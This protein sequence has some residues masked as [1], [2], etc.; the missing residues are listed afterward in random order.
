[1]QCF[2]QDFVRLVAAGDINLI[3]INLHMYDVIASSLRT[4][5]LWH[6]RSVILYEI[7]CTVIQLNTQ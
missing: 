3:Y 7:S 2:P 6:F 1:M 5:E 4:D